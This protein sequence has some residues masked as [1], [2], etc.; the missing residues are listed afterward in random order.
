MGRLGFE[1]LAHRLRAH[2][3]EVVFGLPGTQN[4]HVFEGLRR[5]GLRTVVPTNEFAA[6]MMAL[7]WSRIRGRTGVVVAIPGPGFAL[8]L[9]ALAEADHDSV[10]L[11]LLTQTP[12]EGPGRRFQLQRLDQAGMAGSVT[13]ACLT[14]GSREE[15]AVRVDEAFA[16]AVAGEPGP[17]VLQVSE[18]ILR[19]QEGDDPGLQVPAPWTAPVRPVA[20]RLREA[21]RPVLLAGGGVRGASDAL[22]RL[23]TELRIPVVTTPSARGAV[24]E[25]LDVAMGFE[26]MRT[27]LDHLNALLGEADLVLAVGAKLSHNATAGFQLRLPRERLVHVDAST[28]VL[29]AN[30]PASL[31]LQ[32]DV[33]GLLRGLVDEG[34]HP[35]EWTDDELA[36]WRSRLRTPDSGYVAFEPDLPDGVKGWGD[37]FAGLQDTLGPRSVVVADSGQHQFLARRYLEVHTPSG[38]LFPSDFQSMG[39]GIPAAIGAAVAA[40]DRTVVAVVGDGGF[41]MSASELAV[42]VREGVRLLVLVVA[43]GHYGLIRTNQISAYGHVHGTRLPAVDI[44]GLALAL[45]AHF[46]PVGADVAG[47]FARAET[48]PGVTVLELS[49]RDSTA[50]TAHRVKTRVRESV[51]GVAGP[52]VRGLKGWIRR[53]RS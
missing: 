4:V 47:A 9:G 51:H 48:H 34:L 44:E 27:G 1:L 42:A 30:Y 31:A 15:L 8:A 50:F 29:E 5:A 43:D 39:F 14:A 25:E 46:E 26:P 10:P 32:G 23:A 21:R 6:G 40:P 33:P 19:G 24:P 38:L 3:A 11:V 35:F 22:Q 7:G 28:E 49:V 12:P 20:D 16:A 18:E 45:G 17:V 41:L 13:R 2:G 52:A 36:L 37:V 53:L